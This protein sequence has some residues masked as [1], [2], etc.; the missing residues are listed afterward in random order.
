MKR[1]LIILAA[2]LVGAASAYTVKTGDTLYSIAKNAGTTVEEVQRL[3]N[4]KTLTISVGQELTLPGETVKTPE[5]VTITPPKAEPAPPEPAKPAAPTTAPAPT[6]VKP[7][8]TA[9]DPAASAPVP[10]GVKLLPAGSKYIGGVSVVTPFVLRMGQAFTLRLS[11]PRAAEARVRFT[12]ELGE[13]VRQPAESLTPL[14]A[15]GEYRVLGRVVLGKSTPVTYEIRLGDE[16]LRGRIA[17]VNPKSAGVVPLN[18]PPSIANKLKDPG[19][20]AEEAAVERAYA[21]R[22]PPVWDRPFG[23]AIN[24]SVI[25]G[26]FGQSRTYTKGSE[27]KYHYGA[28]YPA[29]AG[30]PIRAI[31]N[32]TVVLAGQYPVRGNMVAIDHGGGLI[33]L[34]FHQS[35]VQVRAGQRV[36]RGQTIGQVGSTGLS[37]GAHLHLELRLRGEATQPQNWMGKLWP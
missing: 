26:S 20:S 25:P 18:L 4:L 19:R 22:G 32:G 6:P 30:T 11:G 24:A 12:S 17:V 7:A 8:A 34:Y 37:Q 5:G 13:D 3:N 27:V 2:L 35:R 33:S 15:A 31:N 1:A 36:T 28:D 21:R 16:L 14:G 10:A 23:P 29:P 9:A